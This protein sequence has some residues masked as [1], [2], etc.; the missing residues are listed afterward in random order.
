MK[1]TVALLALSLLSPSAF[2]SWNLN[3]EESQFSFSS[4]KKGT[5]LENH[6]FNKM[7]GSIK[8]DGTATL[9]LDLT[10]VNTGIEIRDERMQSMLFE[11]ESFASA[12]FTTQIDSA[13]L[14][15]QQKGS[16][17]QVNVTGL[18]NLHG[19]EKEISAELNVIKLSD[20]K[21]IVSTTKPIAI[22]AAD[23]ALDGGIKA[24]TEVAKLPSIS[25]SVP[26]SFS[27]MFDH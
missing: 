21:V 3:S 7:S 8:D 1:K 10:S 23:F 20:S 27:L 19:V 24:L 5:V 12:T 2:A 11:T 4:T 26:V 17:N 9:M 14:D 16:I 15:K 13:E 22:K 6:T 25:F 18:L